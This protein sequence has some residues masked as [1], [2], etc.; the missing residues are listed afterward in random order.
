MT[1]GGST[2]GNFGA[3]PAIQAANDTNASFVGQYGALNQADVTQ[4]N[5][6][7]TQATFQGG[8]GNTA[9]ISQKTQALGTGNAA[10]NALTMQYGAKNSATVAQSVAVPLAVG[11]N[12]SFITQIGGQNV[13]N[14][15]QT[16]GL[17]NMIG[18]NTQVAMQ[19][20]YA[21][22]ATVSQATGANVANT[23]FTA[24]FGAH[25]VAVVTQK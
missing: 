22:S 15:T 24:Q 21:N 2:A 5:G 16:T 7:N 3:T 4:K 18:D 12:N 9:T 23:S 11:A 1:Q 14:A 10:N 19:V 25:N 17:Q 20:G 8:Y 13:V 6:A